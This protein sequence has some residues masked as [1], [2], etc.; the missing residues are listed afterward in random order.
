VSEWKLFEGLVPHVSTA[1]FHRG[2]DRAPHLEQEFH[3]GRLHRAARF[4][5]EAVTDLGGHA[6]VSDLGCGDGGLLSLVQGLPGVTAWGYDF[7]PSNREGWEE[8]GVTAHTRNAFGTNRRGI[9]LGDIV[10]MT[11]VLEHLAD[12]HG[13]LKWVRGKSKRLVCSSPFNENDRVHDECHAWA[14]DLEGYADLIESAGWTIVRREQVDL[15]Q[16]VLAR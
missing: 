8:R 14:W 11:E 4:V 15:F 2:R 1:E 16:V 12:P 3:Q 5:S 10:V 7:Q 9:R 13:V 6:G